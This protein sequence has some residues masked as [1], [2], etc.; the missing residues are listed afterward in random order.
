MTTIICPKKNDN[1]SNGALLGAVGIYGDGSSSICGLSEKD[2]K[3]NSEPRMRGLNQVPLTSTGTEGSGL[4][5]CIPT[6]I[7]PQIRWQTNTKHAKKNPQSAQNSFS[8]RNF[9]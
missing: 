7:E 3:F 4:W 2:P 8:W 1:F 6:G 5:G 9:F